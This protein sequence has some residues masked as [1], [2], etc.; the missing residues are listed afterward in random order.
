[1]DR[2]DENSN[3][4]CLQSSTPQAPGVQRRAGR[5]EKAGRGKGRGSRATSPSRDGTIMA[6]TGGL[7][8]SRKLAV[9]GGRAAGTRAGAGAGGGAGRAAGRP[10]AGRVRSVPADRGSR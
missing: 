6:A 3:F 5:G 2:R 1:M 10:G 4:S 9:R 8:G 7:P